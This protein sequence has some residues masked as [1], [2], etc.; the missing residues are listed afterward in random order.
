MTW[1][2]ESDYLEI[3]RAAHNNAADLLREAELLFDNKYFAR[4]YV[5]AFTALEEI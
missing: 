1:P 4:A 2:T 3:Y 5:L